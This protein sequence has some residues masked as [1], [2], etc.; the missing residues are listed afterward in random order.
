MRGSGL[1]STDRV[2][3]TMLDDSGN[4]SDVTVTPTSVDVANQ[5]ISVIVPTNAT[6]GR[7]RLERDG[8]GLLLQ[9]VPTL[10]DVN[11]SASGSF[12]GANL[13][14]SGSGFAEGATAVLLGAQRVDD[15]SRNYGIDVT[16][17]TTTR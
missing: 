12:T 5:T 15:F 7:V 4:L 8:T 13:V 14:L 16:P 10:E 3:F 17:P 6:T 9:I 1:L 2:V 11:M